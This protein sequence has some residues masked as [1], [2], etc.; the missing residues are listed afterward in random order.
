M[1]LRLAP[2]RVPWS[3]VFG[4]AVTLAAPAL[5]ADATPPLLPLDIAAN[6]RAGALSEGI[7]TWTLSSNASKKLKSAGVKASGLGSGDTSTADGWGDTGSG[8]TG[9]GDGSTGLSDPWGYGYGYGSSGDTSGTD[10]YGYGYGSSGDTSG[11]DPYSYGY[12]DSSDSYSS[13][14]GFWQS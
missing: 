12:G 5:A 4:H 1:T 11:V 7:A 2:E 6:P 9:W 13:T 14:D 3:R 8:D 10:P